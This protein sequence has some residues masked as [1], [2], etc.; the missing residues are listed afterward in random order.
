MMSLAARL[1]V[2][3]LAGT[4]FAAPETAPIEPPAGA[5]DMAVRWM[6]VRVPDL[7]VMV[8]AIARPS[9]EG[10]FPTVIVLHGSHGFAREYVQLARALAKEGVL[11]VAACWFSGGR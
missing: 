9:G 8:L 10:P 5:A 4:S 1:A 6:Q 11:G 3:L 7:G 2:L